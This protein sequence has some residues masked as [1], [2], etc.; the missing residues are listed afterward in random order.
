LATDAQKSLGPRILEVLSKIQA[1]EYKRDLARSEVDKLRALSEAQRQ[2]QPSVTIS[3]TGI[4][5]NSGAASGN[6]SGLTDK[7]AAT[8]ARPLLPTDL[9]PIG[10]INV[11][12]ANAIK[13]PGSSDDVVLHDGD[14]IYV[15]P[16]PISVSISG[17]V[18]APSAVKWEPGASI[19]YYLR[20]S[21]GLTA[22]A[23]KE[24][25]IVVR[26]SGSLI[27]ASSNTRIEV[28]D[29]IFIP[30]K[31]EADRL[32]DKGAD[33]SSQLAQITNAGLLI[34]IVHALIG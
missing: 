25:V 20:H 2:G 30:T 22:D 13:H 8:P 10:S 29:T 14:Q 16:I 34:A 31:V 1:D 19:A 9:E 6:T 18:L 28:G 24:E 27:K 12:V 11:D 26:S 32:H 33:F 17:A 7:P 3:G 5:P 21:G 23:D 15:P 4:S